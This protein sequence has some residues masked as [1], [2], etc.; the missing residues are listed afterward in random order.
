MA[1]HWVYKEIYSNRYVCNGA[2]VY[3]EPLDGNS[4]VGKFVDG[5][6]T[7]VINC[8]K[9]AATNHQGGIVFI[10]E[11]EYEELKKNRPWNEFEQRQ[12]LEKLRVMPFKG[13]GP[14]DPGAVAAE[15]AKTVKEAG[16]MPVPGTQA[17]TP[18][19]T[20]APA[21]AVTEQAAPAT[22]APTAPPVTPKFKPKTKNLPKQEEKAAG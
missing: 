9:N 17:P 13:F 4:G 12:K 19:P 2:A 11:A 8:L 18:A 7:A 6:D 20:P 16:P 10:T 22:S 15:T 1:T 3:F 5:Q 21:S 14:K